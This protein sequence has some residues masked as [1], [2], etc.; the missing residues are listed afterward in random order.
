MTNKFVVFLQHDTETIE[1]HMG[2]INVIRQPAESEQKTIKHVLYLDDIIYSFISSCTDCSV[3][4]TICNY[5]M[6][7]QG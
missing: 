4:V 1:N 3:C 5:E 6:Q 7:Q 2:V